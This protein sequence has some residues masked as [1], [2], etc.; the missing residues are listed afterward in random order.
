MSIQSHF[1]SFRLSEPPFSQVFRAIFFILCIQSHPLLIRHL[2][3]PYSIR[4]SEPPTFNRLLEPFLPQAFK[5]SF[6]WVFR[7]ISL[8]GVQ[9]HF[10]HKRSEPSSSIRRLEPLLQLR[11]SEPLLQ[12]QAFR[13]TI[14]IGLQ[15]H[16]PHW[17]SESPFS[18]AFRAIGL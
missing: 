7:D 6:S 1:Y 17:C 18:Q 13:A 4:R 3:P 16:S 15:S 5:A 12:F 9:R 11:H 14:F 10:S 2:E 8:M